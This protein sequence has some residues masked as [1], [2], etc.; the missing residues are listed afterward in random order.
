MFHLLKQLL[1]R[2]FDLPLKLKGTIVISIPLICILY[3]IVAS[4][5]F[6]SQ[7]SDLT[8]WIS[9]AFNA[10]SR[11]Q[12]VITLLVDA[13]DGVRGFLL[14]HDATYLEAY[15]KADRELPQRLERLK[16]AL[17]DSPLQLHRVKRVDTLSHQRLEALGATL[18]D[19]SAARLAER[20]DRSRSLST[21]LDQEFAAMR[22]EEARLWAMRINSETTLRKRLYLAMYGGG[23]L[24]L[25]A[26]SLAMAL[27]LT[28]IVR[29][30][31]LLRENADRL[32]QGDA[33]ADLPPGADE[34]G[35]LGQA[36]DSAAVHR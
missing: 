9:R 18:A 25:L 30:T 14:T 4:Q 20:L 29:R 15:K 28:G 6:Q 34:I 12:S 33:L 27:F 36:L 8:Q 13:E 35:Q 2:W 3:S 32:V 23:I 21:E 16:D 7:R 11:I 26:G 10:G 17:H 31:Q 24:S 5:I 19:S 22:A 1:R